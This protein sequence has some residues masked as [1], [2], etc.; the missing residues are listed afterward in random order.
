MTNQQPP[1]RQ[2]MTYLVDS[3]YVA[4]YLKRQRNAVEFLG[5]LL[6]EGPGISIITFAEVYEGI[7]YGKEGKLRW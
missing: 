7:Y 2:V 1:A 5:W 3:D 4:D 6:P